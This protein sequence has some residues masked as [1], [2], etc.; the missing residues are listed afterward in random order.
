MY[1]PLGQIFNG[2]SEEDEHIYQTSFY[3][4]EQAFGLFGSIKI[5]YNDFKTL[6]E[7]KWLNDTIIDLFYSLMDH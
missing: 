6:S 3:D 4:R 1:D 5:T 7:G 2:L